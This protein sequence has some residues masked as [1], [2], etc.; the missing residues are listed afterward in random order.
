MEAHPQSKLER[1]LAV[2][3]FDVA[4]VWIAVTEVASPASV[5]LVLFFKFIPYPIFGLLGGWLDDLLP[6]HR[7]IVVS[8]L[9][10]GVLLLIAAVIFKTKQ[11]YLGR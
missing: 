6:R 8:D 7:I 5:G 4:L 3:G 11:R 9:L 2:R 1:L 10:R